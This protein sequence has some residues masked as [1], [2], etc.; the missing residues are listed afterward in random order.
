MATGRLVSW[1]SG[2]ALA[3]WL[4]AG[5]GGSVAQAPKTAVAPVAKPAE[6]TDVQVSGTGDA[7]QIMVVTSAKAA[8]SLVRQS[9]P[10]RLFLQ[11]TGT[12]L[13]GQ[14]RMIPVNRGAVTVVKASSSGSNGVVEVFLSGEASYEVG[15]RSEGIALNVSPK[16]PEA[17]KQAPAAPA[18]V[19]VPAA[20]PVIITIAVEEPA[21][22]TPAPE[23]AAPAPQVAVPSGPRALTAIDVKKQADGLVVT[24]QGNGPLQH[25]Y[26]LVE[27]RSLVVDIAGASNKVKP[28]NIKVGDPW[29]S[30]I[31]I[32]EH[33]QPKKYVRVVFDLKKVGE[34]SVNRSDDRIVVAFGAPALAATGAVI[35]KPAAPVAATEIP[36]PAPAPAPAPAPLPAPVPA[37]VSASVSASPP[38]RVVAPAAAPAPAPVHVASPVAVPAPAPARVAPPAPVA[39]VPPAAS[40]AQVAPTPG[41]TGRRLSLDFKDAEVNDILR[42]ISEVSGLNFV[43]GPEVK[44]TVSIKLADV[45]WDQALDLILKTNVPQLAQIRESENIVRIT[46]ADK[47]LE[48]QDR[49][50]K[51]EVSKKTT[52]ESQQALEPLVTKVIP[53]SYADSMLK[54]EGK[55]KSFMT[56]QGKVEVDERTK[57]I[58][59][60]DTA[61]AVAEIEKVLLTLDA[62]TPAV[63]IEARIVQMDSNSGQ[64]LG[65]QWGLNFTADAAHGN[66]TKYAFPNSVGVAGTQG[67]SNYMVNLPAATSVAGVGMSFGHIANTLGLD[68]KLSAMETL[69]KSKTLSTPKILV[70]HAKQATMQVGVDLPQVTTT[71]T[72]TGTTNSVEWKK[73]GIVLDVT[74][75][76]TNDKH[77]IM[78]IKVSKDTQGENVQ[79][80]DG[81][82][83]SINKKEAS[84]EVIVADGETTVIGGLYEE[85]SKDAEN[86]VPGLMRLPIVGWM[87]KNK[88]S[89]LKRTELMIFV[90]PRIVTM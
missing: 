29:V 38:V 73:V 4:L 51:I 46:T 86:G 56:K 60:R 20:A 69:G 55:V 77:I 54:V 17:A 30:Q 1:A 66:S 40:S 79:T 21:V 81:L 64:D 16:A 67:D 34:H 35:E 18:A 7:V 48:E 59:I 39:V 27:G 80:T 82:M 83:F 65:V 41:F 36:V 75:S 74:P 33:E 44:G 15:G 28:K 89:T 24:L 58:I 84:T 85:A 42:L 10:P 78:K 2:G 50:N 88:S 49:L 9:T 53:L 37:P 57:S 43:A 25:E 23:A 47:I 22:V 87:F 5:C 71:T 6:I 52:A 26:F 19:N 3:V 70:L 68:L 61:S 11:L 31:R 62:P 13:A 8:Y 14:E 32:G 90:T 12:R 76:V 45:P 72:A 63:L